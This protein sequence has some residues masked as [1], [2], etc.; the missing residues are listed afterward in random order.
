MRAATWSCRRSGLWAYPRRGRRGLASPWPTSNWWSRA[1][2]GLPRSDVILGRDVDRWFGAPPPG[3]GGTAEAV[4]DRSK[5]GVEKL[6]D[7]PP[8]LLTERQGLEHLGPRPRRPVAPG[9]MDPLILFEMPPGE[10]EG[11]GLGPHARTDRPVIPASSHTRRTASMVASPGSTPP[12]GISHHSPLRR[13]GSRALINRR[14]SSVE[15]HDPGGAVGTVRPEASG[16]LQIRYAA[17]YGGA[18]RDCS[19]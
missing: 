6:V 3:R 10:G 4:G 11:D 8:P 17:D 1:S 18:G 13:A 7:R 15:D 19:A 12:P 9:D 16:S 14:R 2:A 5:S